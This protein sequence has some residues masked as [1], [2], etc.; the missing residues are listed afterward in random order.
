MHIIDL[1][2]DVKFKI[3]YRGQEFELREPMVKEIEAF[4]S[5]ESSDQNSLDVFL[6][7]LGLPQGMVGEM[8]V[9]KARQLIDGLLEMLTKKK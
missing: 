4:K 7:G 3:K 9:S 8:G 5:G 6:T 1:G 2:E